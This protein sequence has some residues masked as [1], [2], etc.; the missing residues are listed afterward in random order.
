MAMEVAVG[1]AFSVEG[2]EAVSKAIYDARLALNNAPI[3]FAMIVVSSEY[4][5]ADI[6]SA[7]KTQLGNVPMIG[8]ST[9]GEI[10]A[11]GSQRRSVVTALISDEDLEVHAEWLPGFSE[12]SRLIADEVMDSL[13]IAN[14][15]DGVLLMVAD[16]LGGDYDELLGRLPA[17]KYSVVG[18]LAGGDLQVGRTYQ[19]GGEKFGPDGL[20]AAYLSSEKMRLGV[21]VGHGWQPV[22]ANFRVTHSRGLWVRSLNGKPASDGYATL[23]GKPARDWAFPPLNTLVRLYPLGIEREGLPL[24]VRTPLRVEAD[25]SLRMSAALRDG[26]TGHLLVGSREK[27]LEAARKAAGDALRALEGARPKLA[28]VFADISWEMLFQGFAGAE[29]EAI[30]E[31]LGREVPIVGGYTFG[32]I[33]QPNGAPRPEFLNQHVEVVVLG[34]A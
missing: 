19:L 25:G 14:R 32:Q 33:A 11:E 31:V 16:G 13:Q 2:R 21:G 15:E 7:A 27:C 22:G 12:S 30:R 17:G 10:T 24:Q 28:I 1:Q 29:V 20:A 34:E 4:D 8:F 9:S 3:A 18:C 23:F 6:S 5:F 26:L